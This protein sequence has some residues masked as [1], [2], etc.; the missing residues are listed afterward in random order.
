[1]KRSIMAFF[2]FLVFSIILMITLSG[3]K[4]SVNHDAY[5]EIYERY[6]EIK[7]YTAVATIETASNKATNTYK[8]KQYYTAPDKY[9]MDVMDGDNNVKTSYIFN[10]A[11]VY[12]KSAN[13]GTTNI[14]N[15]VVQDKDYMFIPDFFKS[16]YGSEESF[17]EASNNMSGEQTRL[18]SE[19]K[20]PNP[21]RNSQSV[22]ID[23][24]TYV[25]SKL[26]TY[27][28]DNTAVITVKYEEFKLNEKIEDKMYKNN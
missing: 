15:Y 12:L 5:S 16:Y 2:N 9:R 8:V 18:N 28:V 25:P 27:D 23:N 11:N 24:K 19:A 7:S 10:G 1:M 21:K 4:T 17:A 14:E 13:G 20:T 3:C 6:N 22:W 26:E